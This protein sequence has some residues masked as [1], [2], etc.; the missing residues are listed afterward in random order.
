MDTPLDALL[1]L[2]FA[3]APKPKTSWWTHVLHA[4]GGALVGGA[5]MALLL[6]GVDTSGLDTLPML[7]VIG[8]A[9]LLSAWLH[10][11]LHEAGHAIA[12]VAVGLKPLAFGV[13]PLRAERGER[14]WQL[15]W[16]GSVSGIGG[17]A[18]LLPPVGA[19]PGVR[20]QAV[21]LLGGPLANLLVA[22]LALPMLLALDGPAWAEIALGVFVGVGV[23]I[24]VINLVPFRSG[25][26]LS[27]GAGLRQLRTDPDAAMAGLR[28][29]QLVQASVDGVR[30]RDWPAALLPRGPLPALPTDSPMAMPTTVMRLAH[31]IDSGDAVAAEA[32]ACFLA[33]YWP[34]SPLP[35][36]PGIALT[37]AAYAACTRP[38]DAVLLAPWRALVSRGLLDQSA[39][40]AWLDAEL[41]QREGRLDD[42]RRLLDEAR[43]ALPRIH[44]GG[45]RVTVAE[46]L[47]ALAERLARPAATTAV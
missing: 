25:G 5:A 27:D 36:R 43:A 18:L 16:G 4:L 30:P 3:D 34:Q 23:I 11:V 9:V 26:W 7:A 44:D 33:A 46:R 29:Q 1:P 12:G 45:T 31:A 10:T 40:E 15:R 37:M 20:A 21:Y 24:G 6:R 17:F 8:V 2:P 14:G 22:A 35:E 32:C 47:D 38:D 28:V 19:S 13:G 42:T 41:A 39:H